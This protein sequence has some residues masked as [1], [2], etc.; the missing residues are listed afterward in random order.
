MK[1][2]IRLVPFAILAAA[3][4]AQQEP[5]RVAVETALLVQTTSGTVEPGLQPVVQNLVGSGPVI[6]AFLQALQ[7]S[8]PKEVTAS[9]F[10]MDSRGAQPLTPTSIVVYLSMS[11]TAPA[12]PTIPPTATEVI[13]QVL[14]ERIDA[15]V[16][17]PAAEANG[18]ALERT[19][20]TC[21]DAERRAADAEAKLA[22]LGL[23]DFATEQATLADL[24]RQ[25]PQVELDLRTEQAVSAQLQKRI[26]EAQV[27][28][29]KATERLTQLNGT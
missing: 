5:K 21:Q 27:S 6:D 22:E 12:A 29:D 26:E 18:R 13:A 2:P 28:A 8:L 24:Q 17:R 11:F 1:R 14:R 19:K 23:D 16:S 20:A 15:I 3:A 25:L 4:L 9:D 7:S 10:A